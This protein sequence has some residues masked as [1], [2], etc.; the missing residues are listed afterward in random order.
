MTKSDTGLSCSP[1]ASAG[2]N[3]SNLGGNQQQQLLQQLAQNQ[4][5][6]ALSNSNSVVPSPKTPMQQQ[7][8]QLAAKA[9][10]AQA[11]AKVAQARAEAATIAANAAALANSI[12]PGNG[13]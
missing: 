13:H 6:Q 9:I 2:S 1:S 11:E 12:L 4:L 8:E 7:A 3:N 5:A 10:A